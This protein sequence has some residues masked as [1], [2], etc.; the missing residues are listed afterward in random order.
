MAA[1]GLGTGTAAPDVTLLG[2]GEERF[3]LSNALKAGPVVL[4]FYHLAFTGG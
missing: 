2:I 1:K 3:R 4:I